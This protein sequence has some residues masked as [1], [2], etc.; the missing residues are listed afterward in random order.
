M[1]YVVREAERH[2]MEPW[3][4]RDNRRVICRVAHK[5]DA[6]KRGRMIAKFFRVSLIAYD[7]FG[8]IAFSVSRQTDRRLTRKEHQ[9][10]RTVQRN[11][12]FVERTRG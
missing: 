2:K 7:R 8:S 11:S 6:E 10:A 12:I 4:I 9:E 5:R 3:A 1:I